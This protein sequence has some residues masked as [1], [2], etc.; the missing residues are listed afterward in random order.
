MNGSAAAVA[1]SCPAGGAVTMGDVAIA[2]GD[3]GDAPKDIDGMG[4]G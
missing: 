2:M 3:I 1:A 4:G